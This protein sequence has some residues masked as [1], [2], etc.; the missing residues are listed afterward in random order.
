MTPRLACGTYQSTSVLCEAC[1]SLRSP[2]VLWEARFSHH[3]SQ[4]LLISHSQPPYQSKHTPLLSL[5]V[6]NSQLCL[7]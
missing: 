6:L 3:S 4:G 7:I 1:C 5:V 2:S